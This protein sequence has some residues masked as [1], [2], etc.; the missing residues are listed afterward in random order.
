M[1]A[2]GS[3]TGF[4]SWD[5]KLAAAWFSEDFSLFREILSPIHCAIDAPVS[6]IRN[7]P[8]ITKTAFRAWRS[9]KGTCSYETNISDSCRYVVRVGNGNTGLS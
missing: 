1:T 8:G 4:A 3:S 9:A 2:S 7:P 5:A 6:P